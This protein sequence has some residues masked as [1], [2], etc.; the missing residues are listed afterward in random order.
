MF[1]PTYS[2]QRRLYLLGFLI[3]ALLFGGSLYFEYAMGLTPCPLCIMQRLC[4]FLLGCF[5]LI[6][7]LHNPRRVGQKIY[8]VFILLIA[9]LGMF[10]ATRQVWLQLHPPTHLGSCGAGLMYMLQTLPISKTLYLLLQGSGDCALVT[11]RFWGLSMA[12]WMLIIFSFF[13]LFALW[14]LLRTEREKR[15]L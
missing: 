9:L 3:C 4:V 5:L 10:V 11:W 13:S 12:G 2:S 15:E 8:A 1:I 14:Q 7:A 6:A